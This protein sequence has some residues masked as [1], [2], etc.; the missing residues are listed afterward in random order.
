MA[1]AVSPETADRPVDEGVM[2]ENLEGVF[3]RTSTCS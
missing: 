2:T 1:L 3:W